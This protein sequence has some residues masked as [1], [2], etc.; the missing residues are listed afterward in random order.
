M[1]TAIAILWWLCVVGA[2]SA[3]SWWRGSRARFDRLRLI[4]RLDL[5]LDRA[6]EAERVLEQYKTLAGIKQAT[7]AED[8]RRPLRRIK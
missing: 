5:A 6:D 2:F 3:G 8:R 1:T 4:H 7:E